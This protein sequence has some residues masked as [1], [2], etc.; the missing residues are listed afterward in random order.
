M[1]VAVAALVAAA[2]AVAVGRSQ[3]WREQRPHRPEAARAIPTW[4]TF[5]PWPEEADDE[6]APE[7]RPPASRPE[8][9]RAMHTHSLIRSRTVRTTMTVRRSRRRRH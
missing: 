7:T 8:A 3:P 2:H 5:R 4:N 9:T 1:A 6:V